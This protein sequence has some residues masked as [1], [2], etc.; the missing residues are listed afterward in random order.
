M[1]SKSQLEKKTT[2]Q[3]SPLHSHIKKAKPSFLE[4]G[5]NSLRNTDQDELSGPD[6]QICL[7]KLLFLFYF[8]LI[9]PLETNLTM[10]S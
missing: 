9:I 1:S 8:Y 7:A 5:S 4:E 10:K 3:P 6:E 2:K